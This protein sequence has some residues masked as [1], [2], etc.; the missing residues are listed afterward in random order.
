MDR[1]EFAVRVG[2]CARARAALADVN[3]LEMTRSE[4]AVVAAELAQIL[5]L[6]NE[7]C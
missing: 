5:E 2:D 3:L 7:S 4:K 1:A 6:V